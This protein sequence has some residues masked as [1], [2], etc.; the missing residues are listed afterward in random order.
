MNAQEPFGVQPKKGRKVSGNGNGTA[1]TVTNTGIG[2]AGGAALVATIDPDFGFVVVKWLGEYLGAI[3]FVMVGVFA[4]SVAANALQWNHARTRERFFDNR[5]K[6][7]D[8]ECKEETARQRKA[9][10]AVVDSKDEENKATAKTV[11]KQTQA[12]I[13]IAERL[14]IRTRQRTS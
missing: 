1:R 5:L 14:A 7:K 13:L 6:E 8:A 10:K 11:A 4:L 9:W 12:L 2:F 3:G